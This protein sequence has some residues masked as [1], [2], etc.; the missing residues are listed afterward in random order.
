MEEINS[1]V[2]LC[3]LKNIAMAGIDKQRKIEFQVT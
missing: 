3:C 2:Q 1:L